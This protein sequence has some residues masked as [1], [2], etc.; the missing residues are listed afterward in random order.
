[1]DSVVKGSG[2]LGG[3]ATELGT[4]GSVVPGTGQKLQV[5]IGLDF[6]TAFT[7]VVI[8]TR[9]RAYAVPFTRFIGEGDNPYLLP[10]RLTV[11]ADGTLRLGVGHSGQVHEQ[12]KQLI[13]DGKNDEAFICCAA[14][15][16]L[17][18][19]ESRR[20]FLDEHESAYG[21]YDFDWHINVGL[22]TEHYHN[23]GLVAL[24]RQVV[25]AAWAATT[26]D[27]PPRWAWFANSRHED[28][29]TLHEDYIGFF[30]EFVA[31]I[32]GYVRSPM[33]RND[34]HLL[35]DV[36]AGTLD[37]AIFNVHHDQE[38]GVDRFPIFAKAVEYFGVHY[39][40]QRR[41]D[42]AGVAVDCPNRR[43]KE[44]LSRA[45]WAARFGVSEDVLRKTDGQLQEDVFEQV[46]GV[47]RAARKKYPGS[48]KWM[49]G[50][51]FL[52]CGGGQN[53][54]QYSSLA[55][56]MV[57][58]GQPCA[59]TPLTLPKPENLEAP[60]ADDACYDRLSVAY[61][62]SYD[63]FNIGEI[64]LEE[65]TGDV[66]DR[67]GVQS[68]RAATPAVVS[69]PVCSGSGGSYTKSGCYRCGGSGW[70]QGSGA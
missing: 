1:M 34:L 26:C 30:P 28:H 65:H 51:C 7:K 47:T 60:M 67:V 3:A 18:F 13:L 23:A 16:T 46:K 15:L 42:G 40:H 50:V 31:Q 21:Q 59:F 25:M 62:L 63:S 22:P 27:V 55:R 9:R 69:C 32:T 17:V 70:L 37:V 6:G 43:F 48:R 52:L 45:Q 10:G 64:M 2:A 56:D 14:F 49:E 33:R 35:M 41:A 39:L 5:I 53:V 58:K 68:A 38:E 61:G 57:L 44:G 24:Y 66:E 19:R 29:D 20:W 36:G 4:A 54:E 12:L 11:L 8:R